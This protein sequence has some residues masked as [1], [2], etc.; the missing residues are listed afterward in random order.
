VDLLFSDP[1][2][3][4]L[5]AFLVSPYVLHVLPTQF[6]EEQKAKSKGVSVLFLTKRHAMKAY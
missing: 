1:P 6:D 4:I 5:C 3:K 2:S